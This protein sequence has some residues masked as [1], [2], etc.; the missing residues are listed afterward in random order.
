MLL[1][2]WCPSLK[3]ILVWV[4]LPFAHIQHHL[5]TK[6]RRTLSVRDTASYFSTHSF[7]VITQNLLDI[8]LKPRT[9][10]TIFD[11]HYAALVLELSLVQ[12]HLVAGKPLLYLSEPGVVTNLQNNVGVGGD[13]HDQLAFAMSIRFHEDRNLK[14]YVV[15]VGL[16][17]TTLR[18]RS[19]HCS[20]LSQVW[21]R[22]C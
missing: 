6:V 7:D 19:T 12:S 5:S 16:K 22:T 4:T 3:V 10:Y 14:E 20:W 11:K 8:I 9:S 18:H 1:W 2:L 15:A 13:S 17:G 21:C